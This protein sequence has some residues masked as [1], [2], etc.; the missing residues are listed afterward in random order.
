MSTDPDQP[1]SWPVEHDRRRP[2]PAP[3]GRRLL[4]LLIVL[5]VLG[6][7][8]LL[9]WLFVEVKR[10]TD[11]SSVPAPADIHRAIVLLRTL[12][13]IMSVSVVSVAVWIG[14]FAWRVH[15]SDVYPPPGS[16]QLRVHH[17]RRGPDAQ[18]LARFLLLLAAVLFACG[19]ALAPL[20][21]DLLRNLGLADS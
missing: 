13:V 18:R 9:V 20:L 2:H 19:V 11:G 8:T 10:L 14:H 6:G 4:M 12:A 5:G 3:L 17:V 15:K 16:R 7:F 21:F 1:D